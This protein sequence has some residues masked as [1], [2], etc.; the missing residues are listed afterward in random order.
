MKTPVSKPFF[1]QICRFEQH[2]AKVGPMTL[3]W[4]PRPR[5]LKWDPKVGP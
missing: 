2:T 1:E 5:T 4:D 3:R